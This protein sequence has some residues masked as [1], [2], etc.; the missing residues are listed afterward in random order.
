MTSRARNELALDVHTVRARVCVCF[1]VCACVC[2]GVCGVR[3]CVCVCTCV[4]GSTRP[5]AGATQS[6]VNS[7]FYQ[8]STECLS[9]SL[10]NIT[11]YI[12]NTL[13]S[14]MA[15]PPSGMSAQLPLV[16]VALNYVHTQAVI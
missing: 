9:H 4:C 16:T 10:P 12:Y 6:T 11:T 8:I 3:I 5:A 2:V 14:G 1:Y 15:I 7:I 13:C